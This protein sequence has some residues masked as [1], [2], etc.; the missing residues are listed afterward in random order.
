M[1]LMVI[2]HARHG[3]DTVCD[4]LKEYYGLSFTSSSMFACELFIYSLLRDTHGYSTIE[5]CFNDRVNHRETWHQLIKE[6][7]GDDK[8][9]LT[10]AIFQKND[11]YCG[12]RSREEVQAAR[13]AGLFDYAIWVDA[14]QRLPLEDA[15]SISVTEADADFIIDNNGT[16]EELLRKV[17]ETM[18]RHIG[19]EYFTR[20]RSAHA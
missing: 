10:R 19:N 8:T 2:G 3:K 11:V 17:T 1:K 7:Q 13:E 12:N 9:M 18:D 5:E 20:H 4:L 16:E 14:S 15:S 6:Y